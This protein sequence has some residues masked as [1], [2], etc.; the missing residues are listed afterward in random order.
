MFREF[1]IVVGCEPPRTARP[2]WFPDM[3]VDRNGQSVILALVTEKQLL[4][5]VWC[6]VRIATFPLKQKQQ[7]LLGCLHLCPL[8]KEGSAWHLAE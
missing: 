3:S 7:D 8:A 4:L 6:A 1:A 2:P 5:S